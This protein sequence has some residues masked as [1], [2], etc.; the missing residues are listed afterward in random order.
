V[1]FLR[2]S[3]HY[4]LHYITYVVH[5]HLL[6]VVAFNSSFSLN[7]IGFRLRVLSKTARDAV[8]V[9]GIRG[10]CVFPDIVQGAPV[11]K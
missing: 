6:P 4:S 10:R 5:L 8:V 1:L 9:H 7:E 2:L 3:S 11:L